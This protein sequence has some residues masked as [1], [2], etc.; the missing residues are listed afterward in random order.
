MINLWLLWVFDAERGLSLVRRVGLLSSC[1]FWAL[2][3]GGSSCGAQGLE[4]GFSGCGTKAQLLCSTWDLPRSGIKPVSPAL[5]GG[6][7]TTGLPGKSLYKLF[8][9]HFPPPS[10]PVAFL[11]SCMGLQRLLLVAL[12]SCLHDKLI[13]DMNLLE[14]GSSQK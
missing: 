4:P 7:L 2:L 5:A 12:C 1:V 8:N 3:C 14:T 11:I 10:S 13:L 6:F 9:I